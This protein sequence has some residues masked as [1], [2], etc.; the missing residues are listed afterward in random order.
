M[1]DNPKP[2]LPEVT[3]AAPVAEPSR[4]SFGLIATL[5]LAV[6]LVGAVAVRFITMS[7]LW[8]DE[9]L[10]VNVANLPLSDLREAL[11][12]DGAPP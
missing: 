1:K 8:L 2:T 4:P 3:E 9:A 11:E 12:R 10:T 5:L 7:D 6:V